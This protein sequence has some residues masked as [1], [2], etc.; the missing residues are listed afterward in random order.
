MPYTNSL[1]LTL[2]IT[3]SLT[4][5]W[6][7]TVNDGITSLTDSAVAG[8]AS[9]AMTDATYTLTSLNGLPDEARNM[10]VTATGTLTA[11]QNVI[12]P[13]KSKLYFFK[14][15]TTG[16]FAVTL[17]TSA[18]TGI[19]VPN[20][21][22]MV[23]YCNGTDVIDA[24]SYFSSLTLGSALA[25]TSGG[26]GL[27]SFTANGVMYASSTSALATGSVLTFDGT[28]LGVGTA[29]PFSGT[30]QTSLT[31][32]GSGIGRLDLYTG[33]VSRFYIAASSAQTIMV[34][35]GNT[36]FVY[37][38]NAAEQMRLTTTGLTVTRGII[39]RVNSQTTTTSPWAWN[40][41]SYDQQEFTALANALTINADAGTPANGQQA[42]F[43]LTDD[44]TARALTWT[45][46][47]SKSFRS[48]G[49]P[50]PTTTIANKTLYVG[51][52]YNSTA[53]RWDVI[54]A[55]QEA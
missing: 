51:C 34:N 50:L 5:T 35:A 43:R 20:G 17:K 10:F 39:A 2:P 48:V 11:T 9:I 14:N 16:G 8:T 45:T 40:S 49:T 18:G 13:A 19:S 24:A 26:T 42:I 47:T 1:R 52:I 23:L 54:A 53:A 41:D 38:I 27:T 15:S 55:A 31:V 44:G 22:A 32:N 33:D 3:G 21:R 25:V 46:G 12:C 29:T 37:Y 7:T 30:S 4:G 36:P 28:N 6:G